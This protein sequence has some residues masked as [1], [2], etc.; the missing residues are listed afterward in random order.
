VSEVVGAAS[1]T[2]GCA[3]PHKCLQSCHRTHRLARSVFEKLLRPQV[4]AARAPR[5][6]QGGYTLQLQCRSIASPAGH[7]WPAPR[8]AHIAVTGWVR[9]PRRAAF[10]CGVVAAVTAARGGRH[11]AN[12]CAVAR[13]LAGC[14]RRVHTTC[15]CVPRTPPQARW[16]HVCCHGRQRRGVPPLWRPL[17]VHSTTGRCWQ[18]GRLLDMRVL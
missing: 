16:L 3:A 13:A 6:M 11:A 9:H 5:P 4:R 12:S 1:L 14:A 15:R 2:V 17:E 8:S 18:P 10:F 7:P